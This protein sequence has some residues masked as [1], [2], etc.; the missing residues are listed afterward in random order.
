MA[1]DTSGMARINHEKL[2]RFVS[3]SFAKLGV[4]AGDAEI[5]A[6]VLV[7]SDLRGVDTHGV[8]RFN[9]NAWYVKWLRDGVMTAQP[10]IRVVSENAS[11]ALLD[12]DNGMGFIAGH[13]AMELA[14]KKAKETGVGIVTVRNSRHY[15]MSA[16]YSMLALSHDMIGIAM[17]NAS[18]Q[19][20]P[21]FGR[22]ARFGTNPICFAVPARD[23]HPF[24]LDM[25]TTTAAAGKL[26]LAIRLG[27]PVPTGWALNEKAESTTNPKVAQQARRLLPLGGSREGGSHKGYGL[28]ILVEILCGVL[29]GTVTALNAHQEPR[30]HFFGAIDP[31]AFRPVDEFKADMDRLIRALKSTPP[32]EGESRVY[33]AGEI[34][35]DTAEERAERGI[36]LHSSV[37]QGLRD[38]GAELGVTYDL[39]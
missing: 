5:A 38:V 12:A 11:T 10:N 7:A 36:P 13:R 15:G 8:I 32:I 19:V 14:I 17:T 3:R 4:P 28:G 22:E 18:R 35:F 2:I 30:G 39:E 9:P 37:L 26:E 31:A 16:Y 6:N 29:T 33:V 34:E 23:E 24:V 1:T 21:T 27:K 20:V 25:A